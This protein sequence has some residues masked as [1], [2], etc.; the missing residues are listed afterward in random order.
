MLFTYSNLRKNVK[1]HGAGGGDDHDQ[2]D[3]GEDDEDDDERDGAG[4]HGARPAKRAPGPARGA[5]SKRP[6]EAHEA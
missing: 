2:A 5:P 3:S 6:K 1:G 4:Q